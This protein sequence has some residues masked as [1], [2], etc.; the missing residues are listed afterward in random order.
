MYSEAKTVDQRIHERRL[1][2]MCIPFVN[3]SHLLDLEP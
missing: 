1:H 2:D 3:I